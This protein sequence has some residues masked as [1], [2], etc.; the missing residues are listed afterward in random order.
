MTATVEGFR[1]NLAHAETWTIASTGFLSQHGRPM[2]VHTLV[3]GI[4][5]SGAHGTYSPPAE[6]GSIDDIDLMC[7]VQLA[8]AQATHTLPPEPDLHLIESLMM[9]TTETL[10]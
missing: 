1:E 4:M 7:F 8:A 2:P 10:W 3:A 5:D 9:A 6:P